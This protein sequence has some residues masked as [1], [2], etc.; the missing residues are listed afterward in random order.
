MM[1][2]SGHYETCDH[3]NQRRY[4]GEDKFTCDHC[5]AEVDGHFQMT[6]FFNERDAEKMH[7]CGWRCLLVKLPTVKC[8]DFITLP[9]LRFDEAKPGQG[10]IDFLRA[11]AADGI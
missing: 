7:F 8:D 11:I 4:V 3:C 10:A 9:E 2:Q 1:T 6:V 5:G